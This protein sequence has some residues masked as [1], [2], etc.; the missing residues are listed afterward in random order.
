MVTSTEMNMNMNMN[1]DRTRFYT[2]PFISNYVRDEN[3]NVYCTS[4][5]CLI[6]KWSNTHGMIVIDGDY[7]HG[8]SVVTNT[9]QYPTEIEFFPEQIIHHQPTNQ[10]PEFFTETDFHVNEPTM[11]AL[12]LHHLTPEEGEI[13]ELYH[14][15]GASRFKYS[16]YGQV[17]QTQEDEL[18]DDMTCVGYPI[19]QTLMGPRVTRRTVRIRFFPQYQH[20]ETLVENPAVI[21]RNNQDLLRLSSQ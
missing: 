12:E 10:L 2:I 7:Y 4:T 11:E 9:Q 5:R 19:V 6:G 14:I 15:Q 18:D 3:N 21:V 13:V 16:H 20:L 17:V 8:P 1:A